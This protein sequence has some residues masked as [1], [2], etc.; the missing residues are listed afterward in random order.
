MILGEEL[1][2]DGEAGGCLL[3]HSGGSL[4]KTQVKARS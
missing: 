4:E 3:G 2:W 1:A